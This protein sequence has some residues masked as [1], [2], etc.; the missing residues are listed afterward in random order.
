MLRCHCSSTGNSIC[1]DKRKMPP[2]DV[3]KFQSALDLFHKLNCDRFCLTDRKRLPMAPFT[4]PAFMSMLQRNMT[5][6]P[7]ANRSLASNPAVI[8][9]SS[10]SLLASRLFFFYGTRCRDGIKVLWWRSHLVWLV[11]EGSIPTCACLH[12]A[13]NFFACLLW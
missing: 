3:K 10:F 12:L 1:Q 4:K 8:L 13:K 5:H 11:F 7:T 2:V 9:Q 6:I